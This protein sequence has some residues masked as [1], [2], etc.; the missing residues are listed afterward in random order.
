MDGGAGGGA[1]HPAWRSR[2]AAASA[3]PFLRRRSGLMGGEGSFGWRARRGRHGGHSAASAGASPRRFTPPSPVPARGSTTWW[4]RPGRYRR[5]LDATWST[6]AGEGRV[7]GMGL[8]GSSESWGADHVGTLQWP[9]ER[10]VSSADRCVVA[11]PCQQSSQPWE[12]IA[13]PC[14]W[15]NSRIVRLCFDCRAKSAGLSPRTATPTSR[16]AAPAVVLFP[17]DVV[18][19]RAE[20]MATSPSSRLCVDTPGK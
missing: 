9:Q 10:H 13:H 1:C 5:R 12:H 7:L 19:Y 17:P 8:A 18:W 2:S 4:G 15:S 11:A 20:A 3:T 16:S 6:I 14:A